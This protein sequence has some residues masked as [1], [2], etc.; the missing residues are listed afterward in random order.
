MLY[1]RTGWLHL[2]WNVLEFHF[3]TEFIFR[4]PRDI[5]PF[6][7]ELYV[8]RNKY[9][10]QIDEE[11]SYY[12]LLLLVM[13]GVNW[14]AQQHLQRGKR[15]QLLANPQRKC[16]W[17]VSIYQMPLLAFIGSLLNT[18][19]FHNI[20]LIWF[21]RII[22]GREKEE[23]GKDVAYLECN[24]VIIRADN[25]DMDISLTADYSN[26]SVII[27]I[28]I[29]RKTLKVQNKYS[30]TVALS[31]AHMTQLYLFWMCFMAFNLVYRK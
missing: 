13:S 10:W 25:C 5:R 23:K 1:V 27:I 20:C 7:F 15:K 11:F 29:D 19:I 31:K 28:V 2:F 21:F 8:E 9:K 17:M 14:Y 3:P 4:G 18:I 30:I 24:Q 22:F 6:L 26:I 16:Q 12:I